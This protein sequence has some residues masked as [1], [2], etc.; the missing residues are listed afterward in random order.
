MPTELSETDQLVV[1]ECACERAVFLATGAM[2][3]RMPH[4]VAIGGRVWADPSLSVTRVG[5]RRVDEI[6]RVA[7]REI[8]VREA[9]L[10]KLLLLLIANR[11]GVPMSRVLAD[12]TR[13]AGQLLSAGCKDVVH[14]VEGISKFERGVDV[15]AVVNELSDAVARVSMAILHAVNHGGH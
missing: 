11:R 15:E 10:Q 12:A 7:I 14:D 2:H 13:L 6:V 4:W 5:A 9:Y 8:H 1:W 3:R